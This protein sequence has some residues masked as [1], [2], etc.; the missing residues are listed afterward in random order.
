MSTDEA[1]FD[2]SLRLLTPALFKQVFKQSKR[3]SDRCFTV[4]YRPN[5]LSNP[6]LGMAIAKKNLKRAVDRNLVKRL[7][8]EVFRH[9]RPAL[10][11]VDL[12]VLCK[13]NLPLKDRAV[14]RDSLHRLMAEVAAARKES[15]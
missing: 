8:R 5:G 12:V 9:S 1:G 7:V 15:V 11:G 14:L 3:C 2:R 10:P 4:L 6:R 13:R